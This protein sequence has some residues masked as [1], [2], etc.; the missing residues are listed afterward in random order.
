MQWRSIVQAGQ[1]IFVCGFDLVTRK[2]LDRCG[3]CK[4]PIR[5]VSW[6]PLSMLLWKPRSEL[7]ISV[8]IRTQA[9]ANSSL[10]SG[11]HARTQ[12]SHMHHQTTASHRCNMRDLLSARS[13]Q[14]VGQMQVCWIH[15]S[16]L[17]ISRSRLLCLCDMVTFWYLFFGQVG[18]H[19]LSKR[20]SINIKHT[21]ASHVL[22]MISKSYPT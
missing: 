13:L 2:F 8:R 22:H 14:S 20:K 16:C 9:K 10:I 17:T 21:T 15:A 19:I 12:N 5:D 6:R 18:N 1:I 7:A 3:Y 4:L 11:P